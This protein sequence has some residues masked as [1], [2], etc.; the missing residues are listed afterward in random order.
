MVTLAVLRLL[1]NPFRLYIWF[2]CWNWIVTAGLLAR[3]Q[4]VSCF[5]WRFFPFFLLF[6]SLFLLLLYTVFFPNG[7]CN[8]I[9]Q[10][11]FDFWL[12][13]GFTAARSS[14]KVASY[15]TVVRVVWHVSLAEAAVEEGGQEKMDIGESLVPICT[16]NY[17]QLTHCLMSSCLV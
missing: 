9:E 10:S 5:V 4:F 15:F 7:N 2:Q 3:F 17:L 11:R 14:L 8:F 16:G 12:T 13:F 6:A 1:T